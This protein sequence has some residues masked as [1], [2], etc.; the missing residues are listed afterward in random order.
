[1]TIMRA[2]V[3]L[4]H[5]SAL[6]RD[7]AINVWHFNTIAAGESTSA[8]HTA[9]ESLLET[10]YGSIDTFLSRDLTGNPD[11]VI[12]DLSDTSPRVP[13]YEAEIEGMSFPVT[14]N[15]LPEEVALCL[16]FQGIQLSG[17]N[18]RRRRGRVYLGPM[19]GSANGPGGSPTSTC[20]TGVVGAAQTLLNNQGGIGEVEWCVY[21]P[22]SIPSPGLASEG[23]PVDNG[24]VDNAWDTQRRRGQAPTARTTFQPI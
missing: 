19:N 18:Q 21:S 11:L 2:M 22:T 24:W 5:S 9:V 20:I 17:E 7:D 12:Y 15:A 13:V 14:D 23:V 16:S 3:R 1:M 10:F 8:D 4:H 6:P